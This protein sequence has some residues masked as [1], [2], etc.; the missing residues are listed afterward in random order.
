MPLNEKGTNIKNGKMNFEANIDATWSTRRRHTC[1][2]SESNS[3]GQMPIEVAAV[4]SPP[5]QNFLCFG[6]TRNKN[7]LIWKSV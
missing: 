3:V 6:D 1:C 4:Q 5:L 7:L 2:F